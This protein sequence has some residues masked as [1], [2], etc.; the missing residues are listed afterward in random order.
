M[1]EGTDTTSAAKLSMIDG[2]R[3]QGFC[4][5]FEA[6]SSASTRNAR[7]VA[8]SSGLFIVPPSRMHRDLLFPERRIPACFILVLSNSPIVG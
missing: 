2:C 7:D 6:S 5:S 1:V 4:F 8:T 3:Y